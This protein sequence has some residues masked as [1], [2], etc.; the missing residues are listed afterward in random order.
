M[1][2]LLNKCCRV[3]IPNSESESTFVSE[4]IAIFRLKSLVAVL[5]LQFQTQSDLITKNKVHDDVTSTVKFACI[6]LP[7]T[8]TSPSAGFSS[9]FLLLS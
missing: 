5:Q 4:G 8:L 7:R 9:A 6:T 1:E 3:L 2:T